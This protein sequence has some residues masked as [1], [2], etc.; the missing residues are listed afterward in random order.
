MQ[1]EKARPT[2]NCSALMCPHL[3]WFLFCSIDN[4]MRISQ[5]SPGAAPPQP[6]CA[7]EVPWLIN[8]FF[9]C[10]L[11]N[12]SSEGGEISLS[13]HFYS[14]W[15]GKSTLINILFLAN[16]HIHWKSWKSVKYTKSDSWKRW[17]TSIPGRH[18]SSTRSMLSI[19]LSPGSPKLE[20]WH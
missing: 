17:N 15:T 4:L 7:N 2:K 19:L 6:G 10:W 14:I 16:A 5:K 8:T 13:E 3:S 11:S 20:N 18:R 12:K 1:M 9:F